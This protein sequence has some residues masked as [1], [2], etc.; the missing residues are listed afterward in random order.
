VVTNRALR[1]AVATVHLTVAA[2]HGLAILG[3]GM[4]AAMVVGTEV[5]TV[6]V[7]ARAILVGNDDRTRESSL[8]LV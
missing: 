4:V 1:Q 3:A 6:A 2:S 8:P 7:A 5:D